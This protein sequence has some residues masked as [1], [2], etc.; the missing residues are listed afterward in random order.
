MR[1]IFFIILIVIFSSTS[2]QSGMALTK[3]LI[4]QQGKYYLKGELF[5]GVGFA[6]NKKGK[7]IT[8]EPFKN[9]LLHG[10]RVNYDHNWYVIAREKFTKPMKINHK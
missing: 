10:K 9:G 5:T 8:E 3:D 2:A 1:P 6:K 7:F 4:E